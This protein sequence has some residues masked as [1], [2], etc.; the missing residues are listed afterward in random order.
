MKNNKF[1]P[2]ATNK[3]GKITAPRASENEPRATKLSGD[4][5]RSRKGKSDGSRK[6]G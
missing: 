6:N 5:M 4:D 3:G 2:Y 1:S